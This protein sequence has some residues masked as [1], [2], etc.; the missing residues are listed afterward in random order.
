MEELDNKTG[1]I[2]GNFLECCKGLQ[3]LSPSYAFSSNLGSLGALSCHTA[4]Q[5][6]TLEV[7]NIICAQQNAQENR[8]R[9]IFRFLESFVYI[10]YFAMYMFCAFL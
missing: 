5:V 6:V 2:Y 3:F 1:K 4:C 8:K 9:R 7:E 10:V